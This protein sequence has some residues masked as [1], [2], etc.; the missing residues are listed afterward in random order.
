MI[1]TKFVLTTRYRFSESD[2]QAILRAIKSLYE[3][4]EIQDSYIEEKN[5]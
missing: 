1:K 3:S 4:K 2:K 5:Q